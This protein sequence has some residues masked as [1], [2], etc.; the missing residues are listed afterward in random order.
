MLAH[1][2]SMDRALGSV[3]VTRKGKG[4]KG[5]SRESER[6]VLNP[7]TVTSQGVGVNQKGRGL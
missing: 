7:R 5:N 4:E 1:L 3:P 2:P 6:K